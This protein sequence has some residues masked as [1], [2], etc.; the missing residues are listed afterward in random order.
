MN[1]VG[2]EE[3]EQSVKIKVKFRK[4][5]D[6]KSLNE[7]SIRGIRRREILLGIKLRK[8]GVIFIPEE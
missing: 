3:T 4:F 8:F 5:D 2:L 6:M 1:P 7:K